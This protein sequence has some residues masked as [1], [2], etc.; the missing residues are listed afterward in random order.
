MA[1]VTPAALAKEAPEKKVEEEQEDEDSG[2]KN[3][4][5]VEK[6]TIEFFEMPPGEDWQYNMDII[7]PNEQGTGERFWGIGT[8]GF[9]PEPKWKAF[10]PKMQEAAKET[11]NCK[12][13]VV[14]YHNPTDRMWPYPKLPAVLKAF[15]IKGKHPHVQGVQVTEG[16]IEFTV[17]YQ[18]RRNFEALTSNLDLKGLNQ[19]VRYNCYYYAGEAMLFK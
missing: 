18:K 11:K 13:L 4:D 3:L 2:W 17:T 8:N 19:D 6:V 12:T 9:T 1:P 16:G 14:Q 15:A 5:K 7:W 10:L